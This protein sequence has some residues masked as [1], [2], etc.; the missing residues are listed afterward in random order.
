MSYTV[1]ITP[2]NIEFEVESNQTILSAALEQG[3]MLP[4]RCKLGACMTCLCKKL[5][6]E[7]E[8]HLEPMLTNKEQQ[9]G[10]IPLPSLRKKSLSLNAGRVTRG[11]HDY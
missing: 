3:V 6:G 10:Y 5:Q 8:Y 2:S 11:N 7:V 4:Y 1:L 9:Q